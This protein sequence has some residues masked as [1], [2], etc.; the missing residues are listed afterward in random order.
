MSDPEFSFDS[1]AGS[2]GFLLWRTTN[3]WQRL[4]REVLEPLELTH[5]QFVLLATL[6]GLKSEGPVTQRALAATAGTDP[7]MTSQVL[8]A[9]ESKELITRGAH[10]NDGR[11]RMLAPTTK[12]RR[13][14]QRALAAVEEAERE[15]FSALGRDESRFSRGLRRLVEAEAE[16]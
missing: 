12:G 16:A 11:A 3:R 15:F 10:P 6:A 14:V 7:M 5:V 13:R 1:P 2:T 9:L 8:R 4:L